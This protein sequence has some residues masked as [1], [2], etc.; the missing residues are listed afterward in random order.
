LVSW[1]FRDSTL[2]ERRDRTMLD[3]GSVFGGRE[4]C[5]EVRYTDEPVS[6]Q[7]G[8]VAV[9]RYMGSAGSAGMAQA[10]VG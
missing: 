8:L 9:V 10:G 2:A 7:G 1:V 6:G 5:V 3:K 4:A